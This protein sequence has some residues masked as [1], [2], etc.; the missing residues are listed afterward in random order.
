MTRTDLT[1]AVGRPTRI[2]LAAFARAAASVAAA[3]RPTVV[4]CVA[5]EASRWIGER[6]ASEPPAGK[7]GAA[8]PV[9]G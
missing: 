8:G 7:D 9:V 2:L 3:E 4:I 1:R 6:D 5:D